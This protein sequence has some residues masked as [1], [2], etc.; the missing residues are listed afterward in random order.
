[1]PGK[2]E[3]MRAVRLGLDS[4]RGKGKRTA[5]DKE[6]TSAI[7]TELCRIG[8]CKFRCQVGAR[9]NEVDETHLDYGEWLY[10]VTW[11]EYGGDGQLVD[12][13]LERDD[14]SLE[15]H[16]TPPDAAAIGQIGPP[17]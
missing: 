2:L 6:W 12:A 4:L 16:H 7:K 17:T 14:R 8:R 9:K 5:R 10:D 1:M 11:L 15:V 3:I 13:H